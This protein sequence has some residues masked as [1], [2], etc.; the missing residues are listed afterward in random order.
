M[1][2]KWEEIKKRWFALV[3]TGCILGISCPVGATNEEA[4]LLNYKSIFTVC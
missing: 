4:L 1:K 3:T 2:M